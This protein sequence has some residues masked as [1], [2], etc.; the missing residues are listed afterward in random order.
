MS[1]SNFYLWT[2]PDGL[3]EKQLPKTA[4]AI[5]TKNFVIDECLAQGL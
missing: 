2:A 5:E 4:A 1:K 3:F